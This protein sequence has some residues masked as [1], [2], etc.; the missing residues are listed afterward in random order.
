[1]MVVDDSGGARHPGKEG[2]PGPGCPVPAARHLQLPRRPP[3]G[4]QQCTSQ[5]THQLRYFSFN[6]YSLYLNNLLLLLIQINTIVQNYIYYY[7]NR[8]KHHST[9]LKPAINPP[10]SLS[11][12]HIQLDN[13][14]ICVLAI[15]LI[16]LQN[17]KYLKNDKD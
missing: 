16:F 4:H 12:L 10:F 5:S 9:G 15:V 7:I 11:S 14:M 17:N 8:D 3:L 13:I 6:N 2:V 1:M